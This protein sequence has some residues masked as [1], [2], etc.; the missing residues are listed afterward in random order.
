LRGI[1]YWRLRRDL[2]HWYSSR[3]YTRRPRNLL[4]LLLRTHCR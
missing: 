4:L 2:N 3:L 1:H